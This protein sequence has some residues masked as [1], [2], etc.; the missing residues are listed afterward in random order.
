MLAWS[1]RMSN[2]ELGVLACYLPFDSHTLD[3]V[4][5][6]LSVR[7]FEVLVR[8]VSKSIL[9]RFN[10]GSGLF[11]ST[12]SYRVR[13]GLCMYY[14]RRWA[15]TWENLRSHT[16][17]SARDDAIMW[18]IDDA[19]TYKAETPIVKMI[20]A[21]LV[22]EEYPFGGAK[23]LLGLWGAK[24]DRR[25]LVGSVAEWARRRTQTSYDVDVSGLFE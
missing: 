24:L 3:T 2:H 25:L 1:L 15:R 19:I 20:L 13:P 5:S 4:R 7:D 12:L 17:K 8:C 22:K 11:Q 9:S 23:R 6:F 16:K 10:L 18:F 14:M 21:L